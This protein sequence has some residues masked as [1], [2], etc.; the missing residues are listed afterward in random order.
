MGTDLSGLVVLTGGS[1]PDSNGQWT[2]DYARDFGQYSPNNPPG[3][4]NGQIF[5]SA[6][7]H[8]I[9]PKS[10]DPTMQDPTFDLNYAD[11]GTIFLDSS[12]RS[13]GDR[14]RLLMLY[15]GTNRCIGD[16]GGNNDGNNF[17]S[18]LGVA[19][20]LDYGHTWP[21]YRNNWVALPGQ[22]S[23][24]GPNVPLGA[25]GSG[26]CF[27]NDCSVPPPA[28][29]GRYA[30]LSPHT[31]AADLVL[32]GAKL[33]DNFGDSEPS[34]FVDDIHGD[35]GPGHYV[36][37]VDSYHSPDDTNQ[38][39]TVSGAWLDGGTAPLRFMKWNGSSF[40]EP[41]M[42]NAGGVSALIFPVDNTRYQNC[43][44]AQQNITSGAI[45]YVEETQQYLL[46]FVCTSP[47]DPVSQT[48]KKGSAWF[49]STMDAK[50]SD[51]SGQTQW[52]T[53]QEI[54][55]SWQ[56]FVEQMTGLNTTC[57]SSAWYPTYMSLHHAPGHLSTIVGVARDGS[58]WEDG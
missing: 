15:E 20:S 6:M 17:Y 28:G 38:G 25:F 41:G 8:H 54:V 11:P 40:S 58:R 39:L 48:G 55:G 22:N 45:S 35:D 1:G 52:S 18:T 44:A 47:N 10:P 46:T 2:L 9:C 56:E 19:T 23:S 29:Y 14:G 34:V 13:Q 3:E 24:A 51:L 7:S 53:P 26:I 43:L 27:G 12:V 5:L 37:A 33:T 16:K 31:T 49:F 21:S 50:R 36:Y 4:Q 57:S 30:V 32:L 42:G